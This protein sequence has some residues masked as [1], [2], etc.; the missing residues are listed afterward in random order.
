MRAELQTAH[1]LGEQLLSLAQHAQDSAM[2]VVAHRAFGA[3]LF[4][5]GEPASAHTHFAQG[6]VLYDA[7]QHRSSAFLY[8]EDAGV[9]CHTYAAWALWYLGYPDQGLTRCHEA[10]TLAQQ[11]A[12]LFSLSFVLSW[13][14][15]FHQ[16]RREVRLTQERAEAAISIATEQGFPLWMALGSILRGWA[17]VQQ[18]QAQKGIEQM[19]QGLT[20]WRATGA[21]MLRPYWLSAPRRSPW[22][23]GTA[24]GRTHGARGSAD[25]CRQNW[26][27]AL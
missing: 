14:A 10:L 3:T 17:L 25:P 20:A 7:P 2:L 19:H 27:T 22:H 6:M 21:E 9:Q 23:Y 8:G 13:A 26:R 24:R 4:F 12:H 18:G 1:E 16:F 15:V 11:S 5:M